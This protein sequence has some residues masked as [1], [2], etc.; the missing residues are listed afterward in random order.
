MSPLRLF[1]VKN[2]SN[3]SASQ[4]FEC[5]LCFENYDE[6]KYCPRLLNCGHTFCSFCLQALFR[7]G[8]IECPQDRSVVSVEGGVHSLPKNFALLQLIPSKPVHLDDTSARYCD[9]CDDQKHIAESYCQDC[10]QALCCVM[11]KAHAKLQASK[12]H[13]VV[14]L[15]EA[16]KAENFKH[17]SCPSHGKAYGYFDTGCKQVVCSTCLSVSHRGHLVIPLSIAAE[18]LQREISLTPQRASNELKKVISAK[19]E[20]ADMLCCLQKVHQESNAK[21]E[22]TFEQVG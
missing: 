6:V 22:G 19:E 8:R 15:L 18:R 10:K 12:S 1:L 21:I 7:S 14:S 4:V 5:S 20:L 9:V 11:A 16:G 2:L 17:V 3:M 13:T